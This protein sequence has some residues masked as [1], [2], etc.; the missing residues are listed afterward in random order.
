MISG[1]IEMSEL[2]EYL[3]Q[4]F[5]RESLRYYGYND[6]DE[7]DFVVDAWLDDA[8]NSTHRYK[9]MYDYIGEEKICNGRILDMASGCGT[10][11]FYGLLNGFNVF[12]VEPEDW[13]NTF[14]QMKIDAYGYFE[15]WKS[16]FIKSVGE[17]LPFRDK[18]F[19][20][21]SSYQTLEHVQ[22][23]NKCLSEM[24]RVARVAVFLRAP[25]Y[26]GTFEGHYHLPWFP[27]FP[28]PLARLY[29]R[30][31]GRPIL[32]LDTIQY[33]TGRR[34]KKALR[35]YP[36]EVYDQQRLELTAIKIRKRL[37]LNKMGWLGILMGWIG[38]WGWRLLNKFRRLFRGEK[39]INL[40]IVKVSS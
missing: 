10:F 9:D 27:L 28:R 36:V 7:V 23:V 22:D 38:A 8:G 34:I 1:Q 31:L 33:V 12:G 3:L 16:H 11:V 4:N 37:R 26:S 30:L 5:V 25:D 17:R 39:T 15:D 35:D 29:L 40:V 6:R 32:G 21:V 24:I 2:R 13:K 20:F 18:S 14:N 19:D